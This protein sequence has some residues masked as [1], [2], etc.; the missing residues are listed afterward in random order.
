[1]LGLQTG[2]PARSLTEGLAASA[3]NGEGV[4]AGVNGA[5]QPGV[6]GVTVL[7]LH[8]LGH[9]LLTP[10]EVVAVDVIL[11]VSVRLWTHELELVLA[12]GWKKKDAPVRTIDKIEELT[13]D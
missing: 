11:E 12:L 6:E 3:V 2:I 7:A 4:V 8:R 13:Q 5:P 9:A 10:P 1:M